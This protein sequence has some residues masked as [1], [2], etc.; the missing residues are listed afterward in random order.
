MTRHFTFPA[1]TLLVLAF[2]TT[3]A[4]S[5]TRLYVAPDGRDAFSGTIAEVNAEKTDGPFATLGAARD[6]IRKMKEAGGLP[7]G[8]V[9]VEIGGGD[10]CLS[11]A[12]T[13]DKQDSGTKD[14]PIVYRGAKGQTARLIGGRFVD[15]FEPVMDPAVLARLDDAAKK[16]V[17]CANLKKLGITN[18]G[19]PAGGMEVF[20]R[21]QPM[22]LSR[23]PNEGF[24]RIADIVVDDGHKIH[25]IKG[26]KVG[27]F[28][29]E[30]DRPKRWVGEKDARLHGYW[31]WDWSD[32]RQPIESIDAEK[33]I[34]TLGGTAHGYGYRKGQWYY[35]FNILAELDAPGEWYLDR[36][37]GVLY[38]WPPEEI[39]PGDVI[40]STIGSLVSANDIEYVTFE[41]VTFDVCQGTAVVV[42][43]GSHD[44][45]AD[46]VVKNAGGSAISFSGGKEDTVRGCTVFNIGSGGISVSGG[47]RK[48]LTPA[49]HKVVGNEIYHYGRIKRMYSSGV[50]VHG[51]GNYV[52]NNLIHSAPHIAIMFGGNDHLF[53]LNEIHHVCMES[54]DAGAI[55][56]GR[57]WTM[58]GTV[59]RNNF[60]HHIT[61]F[62]NRGCVGVYLDDMYCGTRIEGNVFY[63]V[64]RAAFIGGGRDCTVEGN[65]FIDCNPALHIDAR[66]LGWAKYH[67]ATTMTDRLNEMPY[68]NDLWKSRYPGLIGIL[69]DEPGAP[70]GN[71]VVGNVSTGG[72]WDG[73][74]SDARK[75][76][77]F[78]NNWT[79]ADLDFGER[80]SLQFALPDDSPVY[81]K[82]PGFKK[83]PF[84]KIGR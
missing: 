36:E 52:G 62:E 59:I 53:E 58:R 22:M 47:D 71:R 73:V 76:V 8:G 18:F 84:E 17:V 25:G 33:R 49:K 63:Q 9:V 42:G 45:V 12:L 19:G 57:D 29:Y 2:L 81:T 37:T 7:E 26:S 38:F 67:V 24:V 83:I 48:T 10:Y 74:H 16:H 82:V 80:E 28:V 61:G 32:E 50:H 43:N 56:A 1:L 70:K 15:A 46:C 14:A 39:R 31:F 13:L 79:D 72:K 66:A 27:K 55:Y 44:T 11:E 65:L 35:A 5:Q 20:F 68:K 6:A 40:V 4:L 30:G 51:V 21:D 78:E 77:H 23:W 60:L 3:P 64:T 75:Y 34:I 69:D 41:N 54:N